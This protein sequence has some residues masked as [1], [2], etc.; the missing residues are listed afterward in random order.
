MKPII[1]EK[2]KDGKLQ[3]TVDEIKKMVEDAYEAGYEDGRKAV[4]I[5]I[6]STPFYT[7]MPN[8]TPWIDRDHIVIT[9]KTLPE[10]L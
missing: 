9:C 10:N 3:V 5:T 2:D 7:P 8:T 1:L 4:P 6:P